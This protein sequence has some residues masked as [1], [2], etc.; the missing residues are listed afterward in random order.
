MQ[1]TSKKRSINPISTDTEIKLLSSAHL[2]SPENQ[3]ILLK[4]VELLVLDNK[5]VTAIELCEEHFKIY[6]ENAEVYLTLAYLYHKEGRLENLEHI[7]KLSSA[8]A[9]RVEV[10]LFIA[11]AYARQNN[12]LEAISYLQTVKNYHSLNIPCLRLLLDSYVFLD[13]PNA[14]CKIYRSLSLTQQA[15]S[16]LVSHYLKALFKLEDIS[17]INQLLNHDKL[18]K[19]Y[20]LDNASHIDCTELNQ[21]LSQYFITHHRRQFEPGNHTTRHGDQIHFEGN[22][23]RSTKILESKIKACLETYLA[24][25]EFATDATHQCYSLQMWANIL[26]NGG[27]QISHIHPDALISGV[28]YISTPKSLKSEDTLT[29]REGWLVFSQA[30]SQ[31]Q[32]YVKPEEGLLVLFP[33]YFFHETVPIKYNE[34]RICV[35]FDVVKEQPTLELTP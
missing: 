13:K 27:H 20:S 25:T 18:I 19:Q 10:Q 4:L 34:S 7:A 15:D 35:A 16:G 24:E 29:H 14:V 17:K 2:K 8:S 30:E 22:W 23:H 1:W 26:G 31:K 12:T 21:E 9:T 32:K 6:S 33:S 5:I 3:S 28:Y 11:N